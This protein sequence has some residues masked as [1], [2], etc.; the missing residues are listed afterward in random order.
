MTVTEPRFQD[1]VGTA[2]RT[3]RENWRAIALISLAG[4][5]L[6]SA[7]QLAG[8]SAPQ[9]LMPLSLVSTGVN[10]AIYAAFVV[11]ALRGGRPPLTPAEAARLW[12]A[13]LI[14]GFF[15]LIVAVV[16]LIPGSMFL[17]AGPYAKY[18]PALQSAGQDNAAVLAVFQRIWQENPWP[19]IGC[20]VFY[21]LIFFY[22]STRL[23][24]AAPATVDRGRILT[25]E[26]WVWTKKAVGKIVTARILLIAPAWVLANA[27]VYLLGRAVAEGSPFLL[28]VFAAGV[29]IGN[30]L[31]GA[32]GAALSTALYRDLGG[33]NAQLPPR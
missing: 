8:A 7:L 33:T 9:L 13:M 28:A 32:L 17:V 20:M 30:I 14:I 12:A 10:S 23:Y 15:M 24:L 6:S 21:G 29:F 4:A 26:T 5:I 19:M 2:L 18:V 1:S 11:I 25:F 22:L 16:T 3:V 27:I 31:Y